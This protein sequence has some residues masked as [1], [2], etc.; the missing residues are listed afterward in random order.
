MTIS[1]LIGTLAFIGAMISLTVQV[2]EKRKDKKEAV[3]RAQR[4]IREDLDYQSRRD[5]V[6]DLVRQLETERKRTEFL[7]DLVDK[8]RVRHRELLDR[9]DISLTE[10]EDMMR[11]ITELEHQINQLKRNQ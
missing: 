4:K 9:M 6:D 10:K 2:L 3:E 5:F 1:A 7:A 8:L 11:K